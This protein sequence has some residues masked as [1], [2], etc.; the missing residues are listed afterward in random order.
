MGKDI[1]SLQVRD[2]LHLLFHGHWWI[3]V[4]LL[5]HEIFGLSD[6]YA[7]LVVHDLWM[8]DSL[9]EDTFNTPLPRLRKILRHFCQVLWA[10]SQ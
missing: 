2:E 7:W 1:L 5:P 9:E 8:Y 10:V 3:F 4:P 6:E